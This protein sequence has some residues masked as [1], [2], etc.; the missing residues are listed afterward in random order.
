M[1]RRSILLDVKMDLAESYL[2]G[3]A[4]GNSASYAFNIQGGKTGIVLPRELLG[5]NPDLNQSA[6]L[7]I[8]TVTGNVSLRSKVKAGR[9][10]IEIF[11]DELIERLAVNEPTSI[12]ILLLEEDNQVV[13]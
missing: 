11:D 6:I 8:K 5:G 13:E 9:D 10:M 3:I 4:E 1:D 2:F 7:N 12:E